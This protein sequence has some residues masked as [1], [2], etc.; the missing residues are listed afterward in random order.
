MRVERLSWGT[1]SQ[2][3]PFNNSYKENQVTTPIK[4]RLTCHREMV[5]AKCRSFSALL[6]T[7]MLLLWAGIKVCWGLSP[8]LLIN[9]VQ[10]KSLIS[11][12]WVVCYFAI[13]I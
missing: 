5:S 1:G 2:P 10:N 7:T 4:I 3:D 13:I 11:I 6:N 8:I 9:D 12:V